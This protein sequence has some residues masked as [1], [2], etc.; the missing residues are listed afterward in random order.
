MHGF[1]KMALAVL[2]A[3]GSVMIIG[4]SDRDGRGWSP[5]DPIPTVH[6]FPT[7]IDSTQ[8]ALENLG[9]IE[10]GPGWAS[11]D[12]D[13]MGVVV[14]DVVTHAY[15]MA[16]PRGLDPAGV[17]EGGM[18]ASI[19]GSIGGAISFR[20]GSVDSI[21]PE[22]EQWGCRSQLTLS[23]DGMLLSWRSCGYEHQAGIWVWD[24]R[25]DVYEF[26][27]SGAYPCWKKK[28]DVLLYR[29]DGEY[30]CMIEMGFTSGQRDTIHVFAAGTS[31]QYFDYSPTGNEI[32]FFR[33]SLVDEENGLCVMDRE[34]AG[35]RQINNDVGRGLSWGKYGIVYS[36]GC[37]S[38]DDPGCGV[39]WLANPG[40]G[41]SQQLT[42]RFQFVF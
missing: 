25:D 38:E 40:T 16:V 19:L 13:A 1:W 26:V 2:A 3:A 34:S 8:V 33:L 41:A 28:S 14:Y 12:E 6:S 18:F 39:L 37:G 31:G 35:I 20:Q 10:V 5:T 7:W 11:I 29:G 36:N 42:S 21:L 23:H 17:G 4:C 15:S 32:A 27:G 24:R 22:K 9:A 30:T